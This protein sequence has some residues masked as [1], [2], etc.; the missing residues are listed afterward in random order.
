MSD[1]GVSVPFPV[2]EVPDEAIITRTLERGELFR[3]PWRYR[4]PRGHAAIQTSTKTRTPA[5]ET[6]GIRWRCSS[7]SHV[8]VAYDYSYIIDAKQLPDGMLRG[9]KRL[10]P[11]NYHTNVYGFADPGREEVKR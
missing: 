9:D 11:E 6:D 1:Y 8:G 3:E 2:L 5:S 10:H 7:C 4:C